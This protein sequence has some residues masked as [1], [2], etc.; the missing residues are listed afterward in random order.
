MHRGLCQLG[1]LLYFI[2]AEWLISYGCLVCFMLIRIQFVCVVH[3]MNSCFLGDESIKQKGC[4]N[5]EN[6][7]QCIKCIQSN[8]MSVNIN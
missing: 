7:M 8:D 2:Y 4:S 1:V 5:N 6:D 3:V